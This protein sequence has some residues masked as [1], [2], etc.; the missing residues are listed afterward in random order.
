[1]DDVLEGRLVC[2]DPAS[3]RRIEHSRVS[4]QVSASSRHPD[5]QARRRPR[6]DGHV[7]ATAYGAEERRREAFDLDWVVRPDDGEGLAVLA[8]DHG[9]EGLLDCERDQ[10]GEGGVASC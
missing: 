2:A 5:L 9:E 1:M 7:G 3:H 8:V 6:V 4:E 10:A